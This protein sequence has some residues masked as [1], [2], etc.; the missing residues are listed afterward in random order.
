[1][2]ARLGNRR[3]ESFQSGFGCEAAGQGRHP[4]ANIR[5]VAVG[6]EQVLDVVDAVAQVG[7]RVPDLRI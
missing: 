2:F 5:L 4:I 3:A 1:M 7:E 6:V